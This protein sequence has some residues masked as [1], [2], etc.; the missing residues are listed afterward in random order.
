MKKVLIFSLFA[1]FVSCQTHVDQKTE[2]SNKDIPASIAPDTIREKQPDGM[3]IIK[4]QKLPF[5]DSTNF[6]NYHEEETFS[7]D[8]LDKINFQQI[9]PDGSDFRIRYK[10]KLI[11]SIYSIVVTM[12]QGEHELL[13]TLL[14]IDNQFKIKGTLLIAY[15]EIAESAFRTEGKILSN[16][17]E[18]TEWNYMGEEP[19]KTLKKYILKSNGEFEPAQDKP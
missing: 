12:K 19:E 7:S 18:V 15:D 10:V 3:E 16:G 13:T 14:N 6:D 5:T 17:I 8:L 11:D 1:L 4:I 9:F 2:D